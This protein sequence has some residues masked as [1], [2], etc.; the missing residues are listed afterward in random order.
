M[1]IHQACAEVG[2][3]IE[4]EHFAARKELKI[5]AIAAIRRHGLSIWVHDRTF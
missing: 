4:K 3:F 5:G 2:N 1:K